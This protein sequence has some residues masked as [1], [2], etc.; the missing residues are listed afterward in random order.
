M[1]PTGAYIQDLDSRCNRRFGIL[2]LCFRSFF[3]EIIHN[4]IQ[5]R[6]Y[7][8]TITKEII[9]ISTVVEDKYSRL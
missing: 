7:L 1:I 3:I 8:S 9:I 6:L 4:I 5:R 2:L